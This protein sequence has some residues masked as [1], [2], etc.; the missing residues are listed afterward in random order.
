M[1][2]YFINNANSVMAAYG[3]YD[4]LFPFGSWV[5]PSLMK[6]LGKLLKSFPYA[7]TTTGHVVSASTLRN[8]AGYGTT[9]MTMTATFYQLLRNPEYMAV[10]Q[11]ELR[12]A[13]PSQESITADGLAKL[14][15]L[16]SVI[17]ETLRL[18]PPINTRFADRTCP[19]TKINGI[20]I[21]KGTVVSAKVFSMQRMPDY[22]AE[23][24]LLQCL[25]R[26]SSVFR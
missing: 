3:L 11:S 24:S 18:M 14:H 26:G 9:A 4:Y 12:N 25:S 20:Y 10:V 13:F 17:F 21:P 6:S 16:P 22:W 7:S 1:F 2:D 8:L 5:L 19:G 23:M 15:Y